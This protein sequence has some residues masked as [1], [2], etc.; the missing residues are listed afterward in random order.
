MYL[1][2]CVLREIIS[3]INKNCSRR[4]KTENIADIQKCKDFLTSPF[5]GDD[6]SDLLRRRLTAAIHRT[7]YAAK[8]ILLHT[9]SRVPVPPV[10]IPLPPCAKSNIIY[11]FT[12]GC[13]ATYLG[14]TERQLRLRVAEHVPLRVCGNFDQSDSMRGQKDTLH[15]SSIARH[16]IETKHSIDPATAFTVV[17]ST[18]NRRILRFV[19]ALAIRKWKRI[20]VN[21]N[22][23]LSRWHCLG[24]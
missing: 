16:L 7:Y 10:K 6:V 12:C 19:E 1:F 17:L 18:R 21:R 8:P 23:F 15:A 3:N 11:R 2:R 9:T 14:R 24:N 20:C 4:I 5:K 13:S 22:S